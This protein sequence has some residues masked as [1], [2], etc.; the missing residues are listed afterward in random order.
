MCE[1]GTHLL[2]T[3][4]DNTDIAGLAKAVDFGSG[5]AACNKRRRTDHGAD[6]H[7]VAPAKYQALARNL[8]AQL[9][10]SA[11]ARGGATRSAGGRRHCHQKDG[12]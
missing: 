12:R 2:D 10:T 1:R 7:W 6:H 8:R 4:D 5:K 9:G 3:A 11:R